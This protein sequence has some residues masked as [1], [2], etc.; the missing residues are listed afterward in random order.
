MATP[1]ISNREENQLAMNLRSSKRAKL[2][3]TSCEEAESNG[4]IG[5]QSTTALEKGK[6]RA[7]SFHFFKDIPLDI[8]GEVSGPCS[9]W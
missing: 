2:A 7:S 5:S 4:S 8:L 9:T 1:N 3:H 6:Q